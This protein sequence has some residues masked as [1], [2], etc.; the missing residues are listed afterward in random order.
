MKSIVSLFLL[1]AGSSTSF[2]V[3]A[4]DIRISQRDSTNSFNWSRDLPMPAS[5]AHGILGVNGST[6]L[7]Q[8]MLFGAGFAFDGTSVYVDV[9]DPGLGLSIVA[10]SNSYNDLDDTPTVPAVSLTA[11]AT[12]DFPNTTAGSQ[13]DLTITV[14]GAVVGDSVS[15]G[16]PASPAAGMV[17][18]AFVSATNT[19]TIRASNIQLLAAVNPASD[20]YRVTVHK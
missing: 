1:V 2:A 5:S 19:V 10:L 6:G 17:W 16:L 15:V 7:P 20:T 12:L 14:T 3:G 4:N 8:I 13:S 9:T 11:T 18:D